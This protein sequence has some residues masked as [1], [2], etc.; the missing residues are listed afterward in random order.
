MECSICYNQ[1][2]DKVSMT[3]GS[4][5]AFCFKCI[6]QYIEANQEL[7]NCPNCR[8][9]EKFIMISSEPSSGTN[10]DF[11]SL[12]YFKKSMPVLQK[13]L[14]DSTVSNTCLIAE[15]L[16]VSYVKNKKQLD[17]A[18]K[19]INIGESVDTL[20]PLIKWDSIESS[21]GS[22][23][24]ELGNIFSSVFRPEINRMARDGGFYYYGTSN[25][26]YN[27]FN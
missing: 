11:Y 22:I 7:K 16:L 12:D 19:L 9:G 18:H 20:V 21:F 23:P 4:Q 14:Q 10:N 2:Q 13:V 1:I 15:V 24:A 25:P 3:C 17:I 6:L 26:R 5:H 27:Y 8:G